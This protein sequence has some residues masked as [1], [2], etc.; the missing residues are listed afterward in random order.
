MQPSMRQHCRPSAVGAPNLPPQPA[1]PAKRLQPESWCDLGARMTF[2]NTS[3]YITDREIAA[4]R[5][6]DLESSS[7]VLGIIL[8]SGRTDCRQSI[9][10]VRIPDSSINSLH[11]H[12]HT[13]VFIIQSASCELFFAGSPQ[14]LLH[15]SR[16]Q[17]A[18]EPN[19]CRLCMCLAS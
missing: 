7:H 3:L 6:P 17:E 4:L 11:K 13:L 19:S 14:P 12:M 8:A 9:I 18:H 15:I 16:E 5:E 1:H 10:P 2:S